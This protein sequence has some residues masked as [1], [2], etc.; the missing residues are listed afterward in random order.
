MPEALTALQACGETMKFKLRTALFLAL[1]IAAPAF[2]QENTNVLS[3]AETSEGWTLLWDGAS[4]NG[5]ENAVNSE[6]EITGGVMRQARGAFVWLRHKA[7]YADFALRLDFRMLTEDADS[8]VFVRASRDG[9]PTKTGYQ[10][11]I[12]NLNVEYGT[13]SLVNRAK[14]SGSKIKAGEWHHFEIRAEGDHI[15]VA[16]D[17]KKTVDVR[18]GAARE[19]YIG[20]QLVKPQEVEFRNIRLKKVG[21]GT[22]L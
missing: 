1:A 19:G 22:R 6:M 3:P 21:P 9:D 17:G 18:D 7:T 2:G 16:L 14:Y 13:G 15:V 11:N 8:G 10:V 4:T 5:W 12:N 20:L